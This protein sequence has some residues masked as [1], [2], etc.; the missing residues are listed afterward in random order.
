MYTYLSACLSKILK[1]LN[2]NVLLEGGFWDLSY[3]T[4][5]EQRTII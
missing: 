3:E 2:I 1:Q 5:N 4:Q